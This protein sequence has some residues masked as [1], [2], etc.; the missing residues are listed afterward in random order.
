MNTP[1][2]R[3]AS[4][5]S[6]AANSELKRRD[7]RRLDDNGVAGG[8]RRG[9]APQQQG[10]REIPWKNKTTNAIRCAVGARLDVFDRQRNV[11]MRVSGKSCKV[12]QTFD[13]KGNIETFRR[14]DGLAHVERFE[15][16]EVGGMFL[17]VFGEPVQSGGAFVRR[18]RRPRR[19]SLP[20]GGHGFVNFC[21]ATHRDRCQRR[22]VR[23]IQ[24]LSGGA[25]GARFP[26]SADE[27]LD[28]CS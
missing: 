19:E 16:R 23:G 17:Q 26:A 15:Q 9:D 4:A 5:A 8:Q 1:S 18:K 28:R 7:F 25:T 14:G 13:A 3:P 6:F 20:R 22:T 21:R 24:D 27:M 10:E 2:G 12:T 11:V